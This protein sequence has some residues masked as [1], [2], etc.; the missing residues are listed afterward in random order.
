MR[1]SLPVAVLTAALTATSLGFAPAPSTPSVAPLAPAPGPLDEVVAAI[2]PTACDPMD[3]AHCLFPFPSN[4]H[5]V[6]DAATDTGLRVDLSPLAMPRNNLGK[7]VDPTDW[8][9]NDGFSPGTPI[10]TLVPGLDLARSWGAHELPADQQPHLV[11]PARYL[12]PDA[13]IVLLDTVTGER[14]PFVSELDQHRDA[15]EGERV[16]Q[17]RPLRNLVEGRRYVVALRGMLDAEG[18]SIEPSDAFV[19]QRDGEADERHQRI[20]DD[21]AAAGVARDGLYLA[22]DFTVASELGIAGRA[23]SVRDRAFAELGDTDLADRVVDGAAPGWA[24]T[25]VEEA[26]QADTLRRVHL[27]VEVPNFLHGDVTVTRPDHGGDDVP[28]VRAPVGGRFEYAADDARFEHPLRNELRPTVD[29]PFTC[30]VPATATADEPAVVSYYGHGLVGSRTQYQGSS[31]EVLR[32]LNVQYCSM[33]WVGLSMGDLPAIAVTLADVSN[34]PT[35]AD[36]GVQGLLNQLFMGRLLTHPDG[37]VTHEAFRD[38]EGRPLFDPASLVYDGNSQGGIM[39]GALMA[40]TPDV[41]HGVLGATGMNYSTLLQR[42][43]DWEGLYGEPFYAAYADTFDRQVAIGLIQ[44]LWDRFEANGYAHHVTDDPYPNTP[45]H[46]VLLHAAWS[47]HQV[48][49]LAAEVQARTYGAAI[50]TTALRDGRHYSTDPFFGLERW[51]PDDGAPHRGSALV[52]F[53]SGNP[54]PPLSNTPSAEGSDP[55]SHPR[56]DALSGVQRLHFLTTGEVVDVHDGAPYY[57]AECAFP[58]PEHPAC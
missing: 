18:A 30:D 29:V 36:R 56:E 11:D 26:P 1:R 23:L 27:T 46:R 50:L 25:A 19:A 4:F 12:A 5:T 58:D 13:P 34:F 14:H 43:V 7:P 39:G 42:S 53:D 57:T 32:G 33:E 55:H 45:T 8:N 6:P 52:F 37:P 22:W 47:D 44:Q 3:P 28:Q 24:V 54:T 2:D 21:L 51:T 31:G 49:T 15:T 40:L 41:E 48:T 10:L 9:R 20:F 35:L 16:L 17:V 38:A